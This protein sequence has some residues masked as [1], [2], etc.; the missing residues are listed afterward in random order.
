[1]CLRVK[2]YIRMESIHLFTVALGPRLGCSNIPFRYFASVSTT[3]LRHPSSQY[4]HSCSAL[5]NPYSSLFGC[6]N[7]ASLSFIV[8]DPKRATL[9]AGFFSG[10]TCEIMKPTAFHEV[11][12]DS[13]T[14]VSK[15]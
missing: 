10:C 3:S 14:S 13:I 15:L 2:W 7:L 6:E 5:Y 12:T 9:L 8:I 1:M 4:L 11:S